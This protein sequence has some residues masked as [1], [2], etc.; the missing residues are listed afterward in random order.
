MPVHHALAQL[1]RSPAEALMVGDSPHDL[2]AGRGAGTATAGVLW[3]AASR[4]ALAPLADRLLADM[5]EALQAV[6]ALQARRDLA[7]GDA[8]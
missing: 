8:G 5:A 2:A 4:E 7:G 1:R 6:E 3:G